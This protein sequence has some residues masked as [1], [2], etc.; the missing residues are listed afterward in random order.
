[1]SS[2]DRGPLTLTPDML[3]DRVRLADLDDL[4]GWDANPY[5][6]DLGATLTHLEHF[7]QVQV[8]VVV[9]G[10]VIHGA[11][12]V[13]AAQHGAAFDGRVAV[14]DLT[15]LG[16]PREKLLAAVLG[17]RRLDQL[18]TVDVNLLLDHL[19]TIKA[20]DDA[21]LA[22]AGYTTAD[23][24]AIAL[25]LLA[26]GTPDDSSS[27][28]GDTAASDP[29]TVPVV[30]Q[31]GDLWQIGPHRLICGDCRDAGTV[32]RLLA[33]APIHMG[34][35]SPPYAE[36]REYDPASGFRPI[37][38]DEYVDWWEDVQAP[39]AERLAPGGS[40]FVNI[41]PSAE[42]LDTELYVFD[43]VI[44]MRRRWGWHFATEFCWE[45]GGMPQRVDR[46]FKNQFEP[47]YQFARDDW[48]PRIRPDRVRTESDHV[49]I[50]LGPGAGE[51]SWAKDQGKPGFEWFK[52]R[53]GPGLAYPGNRLPTFAGTHEAVG[54]SAAFPVGLP[55][56]FVTVYTD[57]GDNVYEPFTGSGS[58]LLAAH[59]E[60]R[61]GYGVELSPRYCDVILERLVRH[62][63]LDPV[64]HGDGARWS[65]LTRP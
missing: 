23:L 42:G 65:D 11:D 59:N 56:W 50:P 44:A 25:E 34:F 55:Q 14:L 9:D 24:D 47:V 60:G 39:V 22:A 36:Q 48:Q 31:L 7:G 45:R 52:D 6:G 46:R 12:L 61:A 58:T 5:Q 41:K 3:A 38:P 53:N 1:M 43:L 21:L 33:G 26:D 15:D 19:H 35:T 62:T 40:F 54:H 32:D 37:P 29:D 64:R 4:H 13:A 30:T 57:P 10:E 28:D 20:A 27:G 8:P 2:D 17:L 63:G 49:P 51:T 16:W 18:A